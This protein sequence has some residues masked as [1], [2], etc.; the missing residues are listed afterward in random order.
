MYIEL[1]FF[2]K[3][4][5]SRGRAEYS[6]YALYS[7]VVF[8]DVPGIKSN[9]KRRGE[10]EGDEVGRIHRDGEGGFSVKGTRY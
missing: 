7:L 6:F 4:F 1:S 3:S 8:D 2:L 9:S 10:T 5:I